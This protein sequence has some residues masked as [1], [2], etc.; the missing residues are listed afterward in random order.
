MQKKR[1]DENG[2]KKR[3]KLEYLV[4]GLKVVGAAASSGHKQTHLCYTTT[5]PVIC[6]LLHSHT[7]VGGG[8]G[9]DLPLPALCLLSQILLGETSFDLILG[10]SFS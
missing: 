8:H 10:D 4:S 2:K 9:T 1:Y 5:I 3:K 6:S 7:K